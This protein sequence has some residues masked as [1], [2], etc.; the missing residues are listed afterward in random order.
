VN[1]EQFKINDPVEVAVDTGPSTTQRT[2]TLRTEKDVEEM[3]AKSRALFHPLHVS[4]IRID[5]EGL[6][7]DACNLLETRMN[8][9]LQECGCPAGNFAAAAGLLG[10]VF[11][12][13]VL[14]GTPI[15]WTWRHLLWGLPIC[16]SLAVIGKLSS[17]F[18]ARLKFI[19]GLESILSWA[20]VYKSQ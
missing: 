17:Q 3:L 1:A 8:A 14:V 11:L 16:L 12:L 19:H 9:Y 6:R 13:F 18:R 5:M 10:Y 4:N 7:A 20:R 15:H 2:V